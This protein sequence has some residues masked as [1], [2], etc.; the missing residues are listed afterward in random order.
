MSQL[1]F[2]NVGPVK[3]WILEVEVYSS[4]FS[5]MSCLCFNIHKLLSEEAL[6]CS[7]LSVVDNPS[8][9]EGITH[10]I[11]PTVMVPWRKISQCVWTGMSVD[12]SEILVKRKWTFGSY[13]LLTKQRYQSTPCKPK[14][15]I[16]W[17]T[18]SQPVFLPKSYL[19]TCHCCQYKGIGIIPA[20]SVVIRWKIQSLLS[21]IV[22]AWCIVLRMLFN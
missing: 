16:P 6:H 13:W 21:K 4:N 19:R 5:S 22:C 11:P 12:T 14:F 9:L 17:S 15:I 3:A 2:E 1:S 8:S 7:S 10:W 20:L 18:S